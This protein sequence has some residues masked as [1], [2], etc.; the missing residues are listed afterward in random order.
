MI[1]GNLSNV[2]TGTAKTYENMANNFSFRVAG[3]GAVEPQ[4][5]DTF[6]LSAPVVEGID[7]RSLRAFVQA[8]HA[9]T[10]KESAPASEKAG[11]ET[12]S[13]LAEKHLG[14]GWKVDSYYDYNQRSPGPDRT[15]VRFG[16]GEGSQTI[17]IEHRGE[18][19]VDI[20]TTTNQGGWEVRHGISA[21]LNGGSIVA[22][23]VVES[24][25]FSKG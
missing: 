22:D 21:P 6:S 11:E 19:K 20:T 12:L 10:Q 5:L 13:K 9:L 23:Q 4:T 25:Y 8:E 7:Q 2:T 17:D 15:V 3:D 1:R 16:N 14:E 18:P 24:A